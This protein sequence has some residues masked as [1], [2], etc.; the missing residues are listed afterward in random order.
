MTSLIAQTGKR[1]QSVTGEVAEEIVD[2]GSLNAID[3]SA[4]VWKLLAP[5]G[6]VESFL[7]MDDDSRV[8]LP[9][10]GLAYR[11]PDRTGV[12]AIFE[13]GQYLK[14]DGTDYFPY[15]NNAAVF[16]ADGSLRFQLEQEG[17]YR[18]GAFHSGSMPDKFNGKMGL[19][20]AAYPQDPPE[21]VFAIDPASPKL[22]STL[23]QIRY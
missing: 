20:I 1:W 5:I 7:I 19:L 18:I 22:I 12:V 8:V 10:N 17:W 23:Q 21:L 16:N 3:A 9:F 2:G 11:L 14:P 15:P 6:Q 4:A 13:P